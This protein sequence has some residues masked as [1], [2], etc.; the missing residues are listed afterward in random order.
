MSRNFFDMLENTI[1]KNDSLLCVGLDPRP[2]RIPGGD[3]VAFNRQIVDATLDLACVYKPNFAFYEALGLEGLAALK[4]TIDYIHG[5]SFPVILDAKRGDIGSTA[6]AYA[7]AAFDVWGADAITVNP[8][9][10]GDALEPFVAQQDKG[11]F[12]MCHTSNPGAQ[13]LQELEVALPSRPESDEKAGQPLYHHVAELARRWN[14]HGNVGLVIGATFPEELATIRVSAPDTWFLVPGVGAQGGDLEAAVSAG[15]NAAGRGLII[16]AARS[17]IYADDPHAAARQVH[18]RINTVRHQRLSQIAYRRSRIAEGQS[19]IR[20]SRFAIRESLVLA[21]HNLGA[22]KF[23]Q[24][25]LKSGLETPIYI[26]L[27]LLVSDPAVLRMVARA[28]AGLLRDLTFDRIAGIPY[29]ALPIATAVGLETGRPVIYPRKETKGYG[30]T[31]AIEGHYQAGETVVVLDDLI[32]TGGSKI[33]AIAPLEAA[34]LQVRDVVVLI[35]RE[36]GGAEKLAGAGYRF[37]SILP[38]SSILETLERHEH[39]TPEV[40]S[41]V[42]EFL[43]GVKP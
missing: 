5:H 37:H 33:E 23:G 28:Y 17:I 10:G 41:E 30:T 24:F 8:Y 6:E 39:I 27:R 36:Q 25:T 42:E 3:V 43:W 15:L 31:R 26:D 40:R 21:L 29:A 11:I 22:I 32:T 20:D 13:D 16:N 1:E 9:L 14:R 18:D 38:L 2:E 34:G 12:V 4:A 7:R 35:D 19:A